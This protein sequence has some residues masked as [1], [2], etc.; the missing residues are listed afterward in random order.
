MNG[1]YMCINIYDISYT[2]V[3]FI[4][5][6]PFGWKGDIQN[7]F[8]WEDSMVKHQNIQVS[9]KETLKKKAQPQICSH[10]SC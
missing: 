1:N 3:Y 5:F 7:I 8:T 6:K 2:L 10:P 4:S 9:H